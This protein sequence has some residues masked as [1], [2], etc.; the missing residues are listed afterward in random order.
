MSGICYYKLVS[1]YP[2]DVTKNC[3]LTVNEIDSN[4]HTLR[5]PSE[6]F[7]GYRAAVTASRTSFISTVGSNRAT[8]RPSRSTR[9]F[10]KFHLI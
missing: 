5:P 1:E 6:Q 7:P 9:N 2:D 3:K 4:F 8:T 10:V